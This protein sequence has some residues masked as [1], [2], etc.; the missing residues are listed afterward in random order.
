[1]IVKIYTKNDVILKKGK[2]VYIPNN[3]NDFNI[4]YY[5]KNIIFIS[6]DVNKF[7]ISLL[8]FLDEEI[9]LIDDFKLTF[10]VFINKAKTITFLTYKRDYKINNFIDNCRLFNIPVYLYDLFISE[11]YLMEFYPVAKLNENI[12]FQNFKNEDN[13]IINKR[14][15]IYNENLRRLYDYNYINVINGIYEDEKIAYSDYLKPYILDNS[16]NKINKV[17]K[18]LDFSINDLIYKKCK[19]ENKI[20]IKNKENYN[21]DEMREFI[22]KHNKTKIIPVNASITYNDFRINTEDFEEYDGITFNNYYEKIQPKIEFTNEELMELIS[23]K[24]KIKELK[25]NNLKD[26]LQNYLY[27]DYLIKSNLYDDFSNMNNYYKCPICNEYYYNSFNDDY[28][29]CEKCN[30]KII[31]NI[32]KNNIKQFTKKELFIYM[33][34]NNINNYYV[35]DYINKNFN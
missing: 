15:E 35:Y 12:Y 19:D 8:P 6:E 32:T 16:Y 10:N 3:K 2:K 11:K 1:M 28:V 4:D 25:N 31:N 9:L 18:G 7:N 29:K 33:Y 34:L 26:V 21:F 5:N 30:I 27:L 20:I 23:N 13:Y 14:N 22:E 17:I 24:F